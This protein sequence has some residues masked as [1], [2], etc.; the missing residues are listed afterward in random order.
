[1]FLP[2]EQEQILILNL[3]A[4]HGLEVGR[5]VDQLQRQTELLGEYRTRLIADVVTGKHD[6]RETAARL[7][8]EIEEPQPSGEDEALSEPVDDAIERSE[9]LH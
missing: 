8:D 5:L 3:I 9:A 1:M 6:V 4:R 7:P 2:P